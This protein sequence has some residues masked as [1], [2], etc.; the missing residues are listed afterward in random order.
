VK[1]VLVIFFNWQAVMH[2]E[3][4]LEGQTVNFEFYREVIDR[5]LQRLRCVRPDKAESHYWFLL[6][7]NAPS[8]YTTIVKQFLAK[9]SITVLYHPLYS[10]DLAP[11]D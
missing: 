1:T 4:V 2:K 6:H 3:P 10:P 11:T 7:D 8:H 9:K 5:L